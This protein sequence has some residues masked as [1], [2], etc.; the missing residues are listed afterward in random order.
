[1]SFKTSLQR[2]LDRFYKLLSNSDFNIRKVTKGALSQA[3]AKLNP[4]AFKRLNEVAI[5]S[6]YRNAECYVW[7]GMRLLSVDGS[8]LLLPNHPSIKEKFGE[9]GFGPNAD[10][11]RSL[12][13]V[14]MLYDA[15]NHLTIDAE[16]APYAAS[17]RDLLMK[18][19]SKVMNGDMLLLDRG[20]PCFW[21]LFLLKAKGI[22]FC[23][24]LKDNWWLEV[25]EFAES[26]DKERI[27]KFKLPKKDRGKLKDHPQIWAQ[28]IS[29]RLIK[30]ELPNGETEILCTSLT[31]FEK[32]DV[33]EFKRLYH[34][35]W[36][37]EEAYKLLK[38]RAELEKFSGKTAWAVEQDFHA[39]VFMMTMCAAYAHPIEEKVKAE[40]S[41]DKE[42]KRSQK[43]NRTYALATFMDLSIPIF[44][45]RKFEEGLKVFDELVYKTREIIRPD[46]VVPRK[47]K[48]KRPYHMNY[49]S[50]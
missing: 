16:I 26:E 1:M 7:Y 43:I 2:D 45:K 41:A 31:D 5:D 17:E 28:E 29:C 34:Y 18:H 35:R 37:E 46:R 33:E 50:L 39:K 14:S 13:M 10:S 36:N 49:K 11:N 48:P 40:Y 6:F 19:L 23:V 42:R 44:I 32:Y 22:E 4:W 12:A 27:V 9:H 21:L 25:K 15:L 30:V 3:R 24:R 38:N 8:R 47:K 20:Y